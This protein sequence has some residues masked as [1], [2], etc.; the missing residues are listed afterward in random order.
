MRFDFRY[1]QGLRQEGT[2]VRSGVLYIYDNEILMING[3]QRMRQVDV[4]FPD[5][6]GKVSVPW[7]NK[8]KTG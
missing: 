7:K 5:I 8:D 2:Y 3:R 4:A 6:G 1:V